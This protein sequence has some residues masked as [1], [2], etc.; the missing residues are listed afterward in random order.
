MKT[1]LFLDWNHDGDICHADIATSLAV[2]Q[3]DDLNPT[4]QNTSEH[5]DNKT[6]CL[7]YLSIMTA[8]IL[9]TVGTAILA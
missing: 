8:C 6:G 5:I 7:T 9:A 3:D 2:A 1:P 4:K